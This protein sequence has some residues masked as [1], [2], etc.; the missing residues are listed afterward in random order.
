[1]K[2]QTKEICV[3]LFIVETLAYPIILG[4]EFLRKEKLILRFDRGIDELIMTDAQINTLHSNPGMCL[5]NS[6]KIPA[7]HQVWVEC[8]VTSPVTADREYSINPS[9]DLLVERGILV[10]RGI[11]KMGRHSLIAKLANISATE[12]TLEALQ[13]IASVEEIDNTFQIE[14]L[15]VIDE[16]QKPNEP[17][18]RENQAG[19]ARSRNELIESIK[20]AI[21]KL[22]IS[23][24]QFDD[25][26]LKS[27][28]NTLMRNKDLF[29]IT[30][31][32]Y[33]LDKGVQHIIDTRQARPVCQPP[34]R[35]SPKERQL[36]RD[37]TEDMLQNGVIR[38]SVSPWASPIVLVKKKDGKQRFCIDF[39]NLNKVA[40]RDVYPIPRIDDCL[41]ALGDNQW[42]STFDMNAGF[43]QI[44]MAEEDRHKTA[45][46]VEGGLYEFNVMPFGLTNATATF[47]RYMDM[48]L[49]GLKW[50][51]L[52]VYLDDVC[53]FSKSLDQHLRRLEE[54]FARFR[55]YDLKLNAA[56][57][58]VLK[59]EFAYLGHIVTGE[60][61]KA[62]AK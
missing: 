32:K 41:T 44:G 24:E 9:S 28:T 14:H 12:V 36:I 55:L 18:I 7:Y 62:D 52:L 53:V 48:V 49:A 17:E 51:S 10:A 39:R 47:Q 60:G 11:I 26:E 13:E 23:F 46:I 54:T 50:T 57:C 8:C 38:P 45:F 33:G 20:V 2:I 19:D 43:W 3:P 42:F 34:H 16:N 25:E 22:K 29:D 31:H 15:T 5:L 59:Q 56:K 6:I 27:I 1:M 30:I 58:H 35:L 4:C 21:P 61:I 40:I 37:M